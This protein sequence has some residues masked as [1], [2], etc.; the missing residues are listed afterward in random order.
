MND[1]SHPTSLSPFPPNYR[2]SGILLHITS[3]P[4][5]YG[6]GDLPFVVSPDSSDVWANPELFLL[7]ECHRPR[8]VAGVPP[9]Y[10]SSRGQLW[11]NPVYDWK[12]LRRTGYRWCIDR[13]RALLA[14]VGLI[15]LDHFRGF[16]RAGSPAGSAQPGGGRP[17][18]RTRSCRRELAPALHGRHAV[19]ANVPMAAR[20]DESLQSRLSALK[21]S[22]TIRGVAMARQRPNS[23]PTRER[24]TQT[25]EYLPTRWLSTQCKTGPAT[26]AYGPIADNAGGNAQMTDQPSHA[27]QRTD[28]RDALGN[29]TAAT[30]KGFA[31]GSANFAR[32]YTTRRFRRSPMNSR[33]RRS[34]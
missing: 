15:R 4:S 18:E 28:A 7:D 23:S 1:N 11:G 19:S 22:F 17:D 29:T 20:P 2:A 10:F 24:G 33:E 13:V 16:A 34:S 21:P 14:H 31:I 9:D 8:F 3:L 5:P 30:G 26:D 12:A 6:I 27:R 25:I 32:R